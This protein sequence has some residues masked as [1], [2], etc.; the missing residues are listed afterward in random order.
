MLVNG[1][2]DLD[3]AGIIGCCVTTSEA[4]AL[5]LFTMK[6]ACLM[7]IPASF[8]LNPLNPA[9]SMSC[10]AESLGGFLKIDPELGTVSG[11]VML[12][13]DRCVSMAS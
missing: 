13:R 3:G 1:L 10:P 7:E 8:M 6:F 5:P 12:L 11:C 9:A 4:D 2:G